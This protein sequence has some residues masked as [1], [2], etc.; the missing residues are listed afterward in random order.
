MTPQSVQMLLALGLGFAVAGLCSSAYQLVTNRAPS[1]QLLA[2]GPRTMAFAGLAL[3]IL[4]A[5]FLIM[6]NTLVNPEPHPSRFQLVFLATVISGFWS[7]MSGTLVMMTLH[8][9]GVFIA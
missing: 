5:P 2:V 8:A 4:S 6:R 3:L 9:C 1:M 7:L